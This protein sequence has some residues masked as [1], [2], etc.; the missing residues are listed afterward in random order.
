MNLSIFMVIMDYLM[1]ITATFFSLL[2]FLVSSCI[3]SNSIFNISCN[4]HFQH[5]LPPSLSLNGA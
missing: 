1:E 3:I 4:V 2:F 5:T